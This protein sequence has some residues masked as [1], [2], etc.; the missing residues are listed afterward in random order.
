MQHDFNLLSLG[1]LADY[2]VELLRCNAQ[3]LDVSLEAPL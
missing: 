2:R 3:N 1:T